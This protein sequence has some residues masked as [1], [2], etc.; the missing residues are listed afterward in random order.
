MK[1]IRKIQHHVQKFQFIHQDVDDKVLQKNPM[2]VIGGIFNLRL[3]LSK[4]AVG[5]AKRVKISSLKE[6]RALIMKGSASVISTLRDT[7]KAA[8]TTLLR[9][10][11]EGSISQL[12]LEY[13]DL[14][15]A[16]IIISVLHFLSE[17]AGAEFT[18]RKCTLRTLILEDMLTPE[19]ELPELYAKARRDGKPPR[20]YQDVMVAVR[21]NV[22][23][24]HGIKTFG[25]LAQNPVITWTAL[26][27]AVADLICRQVVPPVT[28][29][30]CLEDFKTGKWAQRRNQTV[31]EFEGEFL[32]KESIL[33]AACEHDG[34][35]QN[36]HIP[37]PDDMQ[38]LFISK[39]SSAVKTEA[40]VMLTERRADYMTNVS[41]A[42]AN[43]RFE[44][45]HPQHFLQLMTITEDIILKR[46]ASKE[47]NLGEAAAPYR[48]QGRDKDLHLPSGNGSQCIEERARLRAWGFSRRG[49]AHARASAQ[50]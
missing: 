38:R 35:D 5:Y 14:P 22:W 44:D 29:S 9:R 41:M 16:L 12:T 34:K 33:R 32:N 48:Y 40:H 23:H 2:A 31:A 42:Y 15:M 19:G 1:T 36:R 37:C 13:F 20:C 45:L 3:S 39:I 18:D 17:T 47:A 4:D 49:C 8:D 27:N 28:F 50:R 25:P 26:K 11:V 46:D 24:G 7:C 21:C 30:K 43:G 6:L 10:A